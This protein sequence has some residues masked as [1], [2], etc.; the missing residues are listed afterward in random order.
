M[1]A[2]E[3][4]LREHG[5]TLIELLITIV[6]VGILAAIAIVGIGGVTSTGSKS[7]CTASLSSATAA[8]TAYYANQK[9]NAWPATV[10]ALA[11]ANPSVFS[12]PVG[13]AFAGAG[14]STM[15]VGTWTLT[16]TGGGG[17]RPTYDCS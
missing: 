15:K 6:V 9:P 3:Q 8:S 2:R 7:A 4:G 12:T 10:Q 13:A 11:T 14:P 1:D 5:F 17:T 16:Q